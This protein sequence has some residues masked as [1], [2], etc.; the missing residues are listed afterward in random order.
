MGFVS[1]T[2]VTV[3]L[4]LAAFVVLS[5]HAADPEEIRDF[6]P[7]PPGTKLDGNF[8]TSTKLRNINIDKGAF[9]NVTT[10]NVNNFPALSGLGV[11]NALLVY[12][13]ETLFVIEGTLEVG[14]IDTTAPVPKLFTQTLKKD[15]IF[16]FPRGLVHFQI[17]KGKQTARAYASFSSTNAGL[18]SLP[19]T[20]FGVNIDIEV[21]TKSFEVSPYI[22]KAL[23]AQQP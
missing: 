8:F 6:A 23:S 17:N 5:A 7:P 9:A 1:S 22:I 15:D 20:L 10:V 19:R 14:L 18:V 4:C 16:V 13:P 21:L 11:S 3:L 12:P 2:T